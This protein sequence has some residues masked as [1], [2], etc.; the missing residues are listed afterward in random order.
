[1]I[2]LMRQNIKLNDL[3]SRAKDLVLNWQVAQSHQQD[4]C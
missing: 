2:E 3:E 4:H 1:M